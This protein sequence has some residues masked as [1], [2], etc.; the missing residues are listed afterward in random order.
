MNGTA[1]SGVIERPGTPIKDQASIDKITD[2]WAAK[3]GGSGN[4]KKVAF[5]QVGMTFKPLSMTNVDAALI[6]LTVDEGHQLDAAI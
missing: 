4:A 1:L 3:F 5:L 2:A 6:K